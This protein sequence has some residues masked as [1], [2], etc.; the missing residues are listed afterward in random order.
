MNYLKSDA[1]IFRDNVKDI[2]I[3][4]GVSM[5]DISEEAG[6]TRTHLSILAY[7]NNTVS[8]DHIRNYAQALG[9]PM[10]KLAEGL[11]DD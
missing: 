3:S 11:L 9:V 6:Y 2:C 10:S 7:R 8:I 4:H 5:G 1:E